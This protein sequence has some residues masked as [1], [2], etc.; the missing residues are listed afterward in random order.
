MLKKS[1]SL[2]LITLSLAI[3]NQ[4]LTEQYIFNIE[5]TNYNNSI[6]IKCNDDLVLNNDGTKCVNATPNCELPMVLNESQDS[7]INTFDK[8]GWVDRTDNCQGIRQL[9]VN[10]N[11]LVVRANT[12]IKINNPEIPKGYRWA[13]TSEY[14]ANGSGSTTNYHA[15]CGH[16]IYPMQDGGNQYEISLADTN[17]TGLRAHAGG[18]EGYAHASWNYP[19][20]W[21][22]IAI[23][24]E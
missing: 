24:K 1:I 9:D 19:T 14:T 20:I 16:T 5:K 22:G 8:V 17:T 7:C 10:S 11:I 23:I 12:R 15:K 18:T 21:F 13:T 2:S 4:V 3:S 6:E